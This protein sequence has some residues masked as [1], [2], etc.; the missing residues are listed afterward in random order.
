MI[1]S[2]ERFLAEATTSL[3]V[4]TGMSRVIRRGWMVSISRSLGCLAG[5]SVPSSNISPDA[6]A[7]S[8]PRDAIG[9]R[10]DFDASALRSDGGSSSGDSTSAAAWASSTKLKP[11]GR[12][13]SV[14]RCSRVATAGLSG[15]VA[16]VGTVIGADRKSAAVS[17]V[18]SA[19]STSAKSPVTGAAVAR[20]SCGPTLR[21]G[22]SSKIVDGKRHSPLKVE[23]PDDEGMLM[24]DNEVVSISRPSKNNCAIVCSVSRSPISLALT[25]WSMLRR[26]SANLNRRS[27]SSGSSLSLANS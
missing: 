15:T 5:A 12:C 10:C 24:P 11:D 23:I 25:S 27:S 4:T 18:S 3:A 13:D 7:D 26:P 8:A 19:S 1:S 6:I 2:S 17:G 21:C 16:A 20:G 14:A 22:V 9:T